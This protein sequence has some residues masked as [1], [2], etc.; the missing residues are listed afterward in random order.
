[1]LQSSGIAR[2]CLLEPT[3]SERRRRWLSLG[4]GFAW[5]MV[6][7]AVLA[8]RG[9]LSQ[10]AAR[11]FSPR[12]EYVVFQLPRPAARHEPMPAKLPTAARRVTVHPEEHPPP[13][14]VLPTAPTTPVPLNRILPEAPPIAAPAVAASSAVLAGRAHHREMASVHTGLFGDSLMSA[15]VQHAVAAK[16]ETGGF[17][18]PKGSRGDASA[19]RVHDGP[20]LGS[21]DLPSGPGNGSAG[22]HGVNETV[23]NA[24]F[25][26]AIV[27]LG[28]GRGNA[29]LQ[30]R[31]QVR[32][33]GFGDASPAAP[34]SQVPVAIPSLTLT[35]VEILFKPTPVYPEEA[36]RLRVEGEVTL[37]VF[38]AASGELRVLGVVK[39]LG[40]GLDGAARRAAAGIR[41]KPARR[42]DLPV[43]TV[44][45]LRIIFQLAD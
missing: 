19:S 26:N 42:G 45:T 27:G 23:R 16:V 40:H 13:P 21:F 41:F 15:A 6:L 44:A 11:R 33:A 36:R 3:R 39:G 20:Q 10:P 28:G 8:H 12:G 34:A 24:G 2:L 30:P 35:P 37:E 7:V 17:G 32:E 18:D 29:E 5:Q 14:A 31:S 4:A 1:M 38:F 25:G 9:L 22:S 43:D